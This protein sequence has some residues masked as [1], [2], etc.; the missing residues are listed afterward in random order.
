MAKRKRRAIR[1]RETDSRYRHLK[2]YQFKPGTS[3]N[4]KGRPRGRR[5]RVNHRVGLDKLVEIIDSKRAPAAVQLRAA[6]IFVE[7]I[8]RAAGLWE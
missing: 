7:V 3:G 8:M 2:R 1:A 6:K 5:N 4:P